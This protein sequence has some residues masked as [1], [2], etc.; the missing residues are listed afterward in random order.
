M[1]FQAGIKL[2]VIQK[3]IKSNTEHITNT[4]LAAKCFLLYWEIVIIVMLHFPG[5]ALSWLNYLESFLLKVV[6]NFR[7]TCQ[8]FIEHVVKN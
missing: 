6:T 2:K 4:N 5:H 3:A 8:V 1:E 7:W